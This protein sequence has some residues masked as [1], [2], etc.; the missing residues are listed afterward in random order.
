MDIVQNDQSQGLPELT[1]SR[2][3]VANAIARLPRVVEVEAIVSA[4]E[5]G[6]SVVAEVSHS[7]LAAEGI[8]GVVR[9]RGRA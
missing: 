8:E 9:C 5:P 1:K 6:D 4:V 2:S 3:C 7:L